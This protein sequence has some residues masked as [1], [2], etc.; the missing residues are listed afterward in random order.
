MTFLG[1]HAGSSEQQTYLTIMKK[2]EENEMGLCSISDHR[3]N[4]VLPMPSAA[5]A[6]FAEL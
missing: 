6:S 2:R 3:T 5:V 1:L 4:S